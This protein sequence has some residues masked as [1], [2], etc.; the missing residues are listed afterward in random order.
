MRSVEMR[1]RFARALR[2]EVH[3]VWPVFS[4]LLIY[5]IVLDFFVGL[6]EGGRGG[7][8]LW[9]TIII[10]LTI[11]Y[12]DFVPRAVA[13]RILSI[14]IGIGGILLTGLVVAVGVKALNVVAEADRSKPHDH[15]GRN[16]P[17][18]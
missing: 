7:D 13:G 5:Q 10:G 17:T 9:F 1:R 11:G 6:I 2:H 4:G 8:S 14:L 3:V 12:G 18:C 16:A 15:Q